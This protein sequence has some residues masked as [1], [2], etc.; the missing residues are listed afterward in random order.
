MARAFNRWKFLDDVRHEAGAKKIHGQYTPLFN[1]ET[2]DEGNRC[3]YTDV[4]GFY[5]GEEYEF[6]KIDYMELGQDTKGKLNLFTNKALYDY[7]MLCEIDKAKLEE[8]L[9]VDNKGKRNGNLKPYVI[10]VKGTPITDTYIAINPRYLRD[11]I[12]WCDEY[13]IYWK[14]G[15]AYPLYIMSYSGIRYDKKALI[16]PIKLRDDVRETCKVYQEISL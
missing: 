4:R 6:P 10:R 16:L 8:C 5:D 9:T 13:S 14:G 1:I 12:K 3:Y 11:A 2:D 7:R 15:E